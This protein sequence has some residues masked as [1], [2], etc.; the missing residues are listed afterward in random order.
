MGSPGTAVQSC[1]CSFLNWMAACKEQS[2]DEWAQMSLEG[3]V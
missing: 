2:L 1:G 3:C